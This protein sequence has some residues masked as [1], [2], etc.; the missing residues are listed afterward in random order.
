MFVIVIL[1]P[2]YVNVCSHYTMVSNKRV[3]VS[4]LTQPGV[5]GVTV[6]IVAFQAVDPGSTPGQRR[7]FFLVSNGWSLWSNIP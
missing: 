1:C 7:F 3:I 2:Q 5:G 6:S 4:S